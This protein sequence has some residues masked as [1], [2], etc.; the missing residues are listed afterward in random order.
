[1]HHYRRNQ[2]EGK[3]NTSLI[4]ISSPALYNRFILTLFE[5]NQIV[6]R[7]LKRNSFLVTLEPL[8]DDNRI[9]NPDLKATR[10]FWVRLITGRV[11]FLNICH[12]FDAKANFFPAARIMN[13][14]R[15]T[16]ASKRFETQTADH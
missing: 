9:L 12:D 1:M 5:T 14:G 13:H 2:T 16:A 4:S 11:T 10:V 3:E 6:Y 15:V 8:F 7:S